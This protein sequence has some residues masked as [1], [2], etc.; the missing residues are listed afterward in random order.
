MRPRAGGSHLSIDNHKGTCVIVRAREDS[1]TL[2]SKIASLACAAL[3]IVLVSNGSALAKDCVQLTGG[4]CKGHWACTTADGSSGF[5]N[6]DGA[7]DC[8]CKKGKRSR[9]THTDSWMMEQP[10][11]HHG[12]D[13]DEDTNSSSNPYPNAN[14]NHNETPQTMPGQPH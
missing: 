8:Y 4:A 13:D 10:K 14:P 7:K 9:S 6:D 2:Q 11:K 1:M 5:C 3:T 12:G